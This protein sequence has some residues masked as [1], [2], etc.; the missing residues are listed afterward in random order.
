[1]SFTRAQLRTILTP[2][3]RGDGGGMFAAI[4]KAFTGVCGLLGCKRRLA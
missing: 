3:A 1:M 4:R 2:P